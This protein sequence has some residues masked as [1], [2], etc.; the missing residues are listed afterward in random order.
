MG[1][2]PVWTGISSHPINTWPSE[3]SSVR[4]F[5]QAQ[6]RVRAGD[7]ARIVEQIGASVSRFQAGDDV[8]G[9]WT[10]SLREVAGSESRRMP[11]VTG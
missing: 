7:V 8:N 5:T 1:E 11:E 4:P 10:A 2:P 9:T 3:P 6:G